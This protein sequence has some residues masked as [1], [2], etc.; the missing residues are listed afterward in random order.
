[1]LF[2]ID[3]LIMIIRVL[4][5]IFCFFY[6]YY[7]DIK[8]QT[9]QNDILRDIVFIRVQG[10][11]MAE[12]FYDNTSSESIKQICI[13]L[14]SYYKDTQSAMLVLCNGKDLKLS[15]T[16]ADI[17]LGDLKK[18]LETNNLHKEQDYLLL[19]EAHINS[20]ISFYVTLAK[21]EYWNDIAHFSFLAL[22]E[23]FNLKQEISKIRNSKL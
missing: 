20:S 3:N 18:G 13:R 10:L 8:G 6:M 2:K 1:M 11:G 22:P 5:F 21:Q 17:I 4:T 15:S 23:L 12:L 19:C 9:T 7:G 14:K 16:D